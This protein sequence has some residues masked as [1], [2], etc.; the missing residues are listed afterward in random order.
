M[1][2]RQQDTKGGNMSEMGLA[3][4][5]QEGKPIHPDD[6]EY[7]CPNFDAWYERQLD[8]YNKAHNIN[9]DGA[10]S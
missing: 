6:T 7:D 10:E 1:E 3:H 8:A 5:K 4:I 9:T 2:I